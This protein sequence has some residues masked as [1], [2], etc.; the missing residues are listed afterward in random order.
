MIDTYSS[1]VYGHTKRMTASL[2]PTVLSLRCASTRQPRQLYLP[3]AQAT[4]ATRLRR[5]SRGVRLEAN[6]TNRA[7]GGSRSRGVTPTGARG[8]RGGVQRGAAAVEQEPRGG[9]ELSTASD[10]IS[11]ALTPGIRSRV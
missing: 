10:E 11:Q 5:C 8:A 4:A 1:S 2:F 9:G 3:N 6:V 7:L